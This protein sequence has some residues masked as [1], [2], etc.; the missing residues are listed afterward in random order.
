MA[1]P[2]L[3]LG[4]ATITAAGSAWYLPA[5]LDLRAGPDRPRATRLAAAACLLW[6]GGAAAAALLLTTPLGW[7]APLG[8]ALTGALAATA[9]RALAAAERRAEQDEQAL[10]WGPPPSVPRSAAPRWAELPPSVP[11][12][13]VPR[14]A[15]QLVGWL[16]AGL[17][18]VAAVSA[19]TLLGGRPAAAG[20]ALLTVSASAG[21]C[22]LIVLVAV[23]A[24]RP[25]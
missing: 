21:L 11:R 25:R 6:W 2:V 8:A 5:L 7:P 24:N 18:A 4:A 9:L 13:S 16:T 19:V 23:H 1:H 22:L 14:S 12:S 3:A 10:I 20:S 15:A 17:A